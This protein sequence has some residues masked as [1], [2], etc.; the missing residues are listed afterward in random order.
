MTTTSRCVVLGPVGGPIDPGCEDGLR[1][2]ERRGYVVWR[3]RGYSAIDAARN[4]MAS[5]A[6]AQGFDELMDG[7]KGIGSRCKTYSTGTM[8]TVNTNYYQTNYDYDSDGRLVRTQT[9]NGTIYPTVYNS[10]DEAVSAWVG[11]NDTPTSGEWSPT[12]NTG[13]ANMVEVASYQ[14]DNGGV[15]DGN[16]TQETDYPGLGAVNRVTDYWYDWRDRLVA[17]KSGVESNENDGVNRPIIVTTYDNLD[18]ATETQQYVGDSVTPTISGGVLQ[19]LP[20]SDLRAQ[21]MDSYDDQGRLY[22]TQVYDVNPSTGAVSSSALTTNYYYD[23]RGDLMAE[24]DPGGLWTKSSY[25]GAGRDVMDYTTDGAGGTTWSAASSVASDTVL[26]QVQTVYDAEGNPIETID[27]QRFHNATG[28]GALGSPS[29]GIGARVYYAAEYYDN[30]DRV[31]ADVN[32]GTSGGSAW[33]RPG[34]VPA[35]SATLLVTTYAYTYYAA[36]LYVETHDPMGIDTHTNYDNLGRLARIIQN[37][38]GQA[39]TTNSD[40]STTYYY[41]GNNHVT[42]VQANEP[43]GAYQE[44][45]YLYGVTTAGGSGVNSNDIL[46][47]IQHPDPSSG[48]PSSSQQDKYL[49]D[50]LGDVVQSTDRHGTVHQYGYDVLGRLTSDKVTTLASGV[51]G[52]IRRIQ[53]AYDSQGNLSLITSYNAASGGS[54]VNQVQRVYNGLGQLTGEYQSHSGAVNTNSTPEVHY[55]YNEMSNG[56]NN[57]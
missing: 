44:T 7:G 22:Q 19:A 24:S 15:G 12:N 5:D 30:A 35:S 13:S 43:G 6:L 29:S 23:H 2:L 26:E 25:D 9:L 10:L 53:Y 57:S 14:Y 27:R 47:A 49:T 4:Q 38:T 36:G 20:A 52:T 16:L 40:V 34:S 55:G 11:T 46:S 42:Y 45:R 48:H 28:T 17:Q 56:Q 32:A 39:E 8:G 1:E 33:T 41:D 54:I 51:D 37:Y 3:V 21:E 18:E 31:I 50:A